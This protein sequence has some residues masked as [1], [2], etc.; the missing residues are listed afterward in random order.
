MIAK[1]SANADSL[2]IG[3]QDNTTPGGEPERTA[4]VPRHYLSPTG[5]RAVNARA[6]AL[7]EYL[8]ARRA[9][10]QVVAAWVAR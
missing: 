7:R 9:M 10:R 4:M 8:W 2:G 3:S 6:A 1:A 5:L